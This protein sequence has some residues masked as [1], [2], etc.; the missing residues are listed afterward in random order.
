MKEGTKFFFCVLYLPHS[1]R[2]VVFR[3]QNPEKACIKKRDAENHVALLAVKKLQT[4]EFLSKYLMIN[5]E[6]PVI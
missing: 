2:E 5:G 3:K 1:C 6:H 4:K